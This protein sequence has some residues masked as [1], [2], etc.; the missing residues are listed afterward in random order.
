MLK[1]LLSGM[2]AFALVLGSG[3]IPT[4]S[5]SG[6]DGNDFYLS[7]RAVTTQCDTYSGSNVNK[8]NYSTYGTTVKSYLTECSDETFMR[9]QAGAVD[10]NL[11][12]EYYDKD[13]N[14]QSTK[15]VALELPIF[16]A[17]YATDSNYYVLTGQNNLDEDDSVEVYRITKYDLNWNKIAS[18]GLF[19][20][21]TYIP[22]EAGS[23]RMVTSGKYLLIRTCHQMYMT[24]DGYHHQANVT[25]QVDVD[26]MEITDSYTMIM[27]SGYGYVS[28]SFNQFIG[29]VDNSI[30]GVDHGDA[31]PRSIALVKYNT[32]FTGGVFTP[33]YYK[34]CTVVNMLPI[35]GS[36]SNNYTGASVGGF[37]ISDSKYLVAGNTINQDEFD[38]AST[39]NIF[40]SSVSKNLTDEPVI[41]YITDYE[42]GSSSAS[43]PQLVK[44]GDNKYMLLWLYDSKVNYVQI[45]GDGN[46]VGDIK[47]MEGNLSDCVPIVSGNKL[48]WYT[49]N[50]NANTFY[51]IDLSDMSGNETVIENGH[52]CYYTDATE[53][54]Y[55]VTEKC[56]NCEY[57]Q[58]ILAPNEMSVWWKDPDD[59]TGYYWSYYSNY[60]EIGEELKVWGS[61]SY[62]SNDTITEKITDIEVTISDP[63]VMEY[64]STSSD[65]GKFVMLKSGTVEVTIQ[66]EHAP[67]LKKTYSITVLP[68]QSDNVKYQ[69]SGSEKLRFIYIADIE[70]LEN[71]ET[72]RVNISGLTGDFSDDY[73]ITQAYKSI[74]ANGELVEAPEGKC[75]VIS[76]TIYLTGYDK[77]KA[78]YFLDDVDKGVRVYMK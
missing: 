35:S 76:P 63:S 8:Q 26:T 62:P 27:N 3:L 16:G 46:V 71:A 12:I 2:L 28:H 48:I 72:A 67:Y 57:S 10:G 44:T 22:F 65:M 34:K 75:F 77:I 58:Q 18:G 32:D 43:T 70:D 17:F 13:Y 45:D 73:S 4:D 14:I 61:L 42:E 11:L 68:E 30:V 49:W 54:T 24:S 78:Q 66:P 56:E 60:Y 59:T 36:V 31:Y 40:V 6:D 41:N 29:T 20:A 53:D 7:A 38:T 37:E 55:I 39:R 64:V 1:K 47:T 25:I 50:N 33:T 21:N 51:E 19:G 15:L 5:F 23:A 9:V 69:L 74:Y 52:E